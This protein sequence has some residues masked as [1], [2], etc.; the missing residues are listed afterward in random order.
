MN[1]TV[2]KSIVYTFVAQIVGV[3]S[4]VCMSAFIPKVTTVLDFSYWQLFVFY[5]SFIGLL[6][7]GW[8]DG[9]Y[10]K[11][12]GKSLAQI[13]SCSFC[14]QLVLYMFFQFLLALAG[15]CVV[16]FIDTSE[17]AVLYFTL[18]YIPIKNIY[19]YFSMTLLSTDNIVDNSKCDMVRKGF[20]V[21]VILCLLFFRCNVGYK[22]II[23]VFI[24][25]EVLPFFHML[26][27][28]RNMLFKD[29]M[30][31]FGKTLKEA[32]GNLNSATLY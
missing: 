27:L 15:F 26:Q 11:Y 13:E 20:L 4:S 19:S 21:V 29:K 16:F 24:A 9:I 17:K 6:H 1:G 14:S 5:S 12:G 28:F 30:L 3:L 32:L 7:F 10:L 8:V 2:Y 25:S 22:I 23:I 31:S 18:L